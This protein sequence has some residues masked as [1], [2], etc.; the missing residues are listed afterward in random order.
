MHDV[1]DS[2]VCFCA[3]WPV[4]SLSRFRG[5]ESR[6]TAFILQGE[7]YLNRAI[8]KVP[9]SSHF[10][11]IFHAAY[12]YNLHVTIFSC[13]VMLN[14]KLTIFSCYVIVTR[15]LKIM[16]MVVNIIIFHLAPWHEARLD[17]AH[18]VF[19][20]FAPEQT[21]ASPPKATGIGKTVNKF[22]KHGEELGML[23]TGLVKKWKALAIGSQETGSSQQEATSPQSRGLS[24]LNS[25]P[26]PKKEQAKVCSQG[27]AGEGGRWVVGGWG[28][29]VLPQGVSF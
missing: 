6:W 27:G 3:I 18:S 17:R 25:S 1:A 14:R 21:F 23:A 29:G 8:L 5:F 2:L 11:N 4:I 28:E 22:R 26:K 24:L 15:L 20:V 19:S 12:I 7:R 16:S 9:C 13:Y 10:K